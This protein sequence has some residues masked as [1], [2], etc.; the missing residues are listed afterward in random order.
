MTPP[1]VKA[2]VRMELYRKY[3]DFSAIA[4]L[5]ENPNARYCP[6]KVEKCSVL[7]FLG[8]L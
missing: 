4:N 5:R 3:V 1:I 6:D 7:L 2:V 8:D